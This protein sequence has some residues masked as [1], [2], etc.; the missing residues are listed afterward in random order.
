[1][2]YI[3]IESNGKSFR[4]PSSHPHFLEL[5]IDPA[6]WYRFNQ[7]AEDNPAFRIVGHDFP[8]GGMMT[9]RVACGSE[10][11]VEQLEKVW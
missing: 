11:V 4:L 10:A 9:V 8:D 2:K 6:D 5:K 7:L 1:M 3:E